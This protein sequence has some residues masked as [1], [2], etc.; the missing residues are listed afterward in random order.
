[1]IITVFLKSH[2]FVFISIVVRLSDTAVSDPV[3]QHVVCFCGPTRWA[4]VRSW[5]DDWQVR[6]LRRFLETWGIT[7]SCIEVSASRQTKRVECQAD[8]PLMWRRGGEPALKW[9]NSNRRMEGQKCYMLLSVMKLLLL[10]LALYVSV[11]SSSGLFRCWTSS[12]LISHQQL[13]GSMSCSHGDSLRQSACVAAFQTSLVYEGKTSSLLLWL[14][15]IKKLC[16]V[17]WISKPPGWRLH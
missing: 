5:P 8:C 3:Q 2:K 12:R 16:S 7:S 15:S 1:M 10:Y 17:H 11:R 6:L 9:N 4:V 14:Q 13:N